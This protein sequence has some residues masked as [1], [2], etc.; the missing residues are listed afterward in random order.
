MAGTRS[1]AACRLCAAADLQEII[2]FG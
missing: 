2:D 1:I